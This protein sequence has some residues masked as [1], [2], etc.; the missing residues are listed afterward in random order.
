MDFMVIC[1]TEVD[2]EV[3]LENRPVNN[4]FLSLCKELRVY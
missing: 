4:S 2:D 1:F 3:F